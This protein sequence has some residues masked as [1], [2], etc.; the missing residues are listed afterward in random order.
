MQA[1]SRSSTTVRPI[2]CGF[3][4]VGEDGVDG[5][6]GHVGAAPVRHA[7]PMRDAATSKAPTAWWSTASDDVHAAHHRGDA[8]QDL[9]AERDVDGDRRRGDRAA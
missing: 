2:G 7:R 9:G 5:D 8:E 4:L 6:D 1:A 3:G